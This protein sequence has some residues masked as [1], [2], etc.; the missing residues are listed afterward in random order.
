MTIAQQIKDGI[1]SAFADIR[2]ALTNTKPTE[3][4]NAAQPAAGAITDEIRA[5]I[6]SHLEPVQKEL[7]DALA[8]V[9]SL[10]GQVAERDTTITDL[11]AQLQARDGEI[12][13]LKAAAK[14][15]GQVAAE[16]CASLGVKP[17]DV[18]PD[19]STAAASGESLLDQFQK[20]TDPK[21]RG[22]FYAKHR[23]KLLGGK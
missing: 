2:A 15:A 1:A 14:T 11:R 16:T 13:N 19:A 6:R 3:A 22:E 23:D 7:T 21:A 12:T 17:L 4:Q 9:V 5:E 8:Q 18:K 20:I 10:K